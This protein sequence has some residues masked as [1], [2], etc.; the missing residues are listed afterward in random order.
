M[1]NALY[2]TGFN[3]VDIIGCFFNILTNLAEVIPLR[4]N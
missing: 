1:N 4:E 3:F 2:T